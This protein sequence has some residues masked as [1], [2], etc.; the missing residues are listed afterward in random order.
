DPRMTKIVPASMANVKL[1]SDGKVASY[2]WNRSLGVDSY[3]PATRLVKGGATSVATA[4]YAAENTDRAYTIA[5]ATDRAA[6]IAAQTAAGRDFTV[7][8]NSVTVTYPAGSIYMGSTNYVLA[9]DTVYV[10]LRST[11]QATKGSVPQ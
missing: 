7:D 4:T 6:F 8:G 5:D 1:G 2:T 10:N 11:S 9:G 3:G